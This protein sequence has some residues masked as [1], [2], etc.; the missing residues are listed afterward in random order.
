MGNSASSHRPHGHST[1]QKNR[2]PSLDL[3]DIIGTWNID[4]DDE[5]TLNPTP[6]DLAFAASRKAV[7]PPAVKSKD[8]AGAPAPTI[9][10]PSSHIQ[11]PPTIEEV[12]TTQPAEFTQVTVMSILPT[13]QKVEVPAV[14][15]EPITITWNGPGKAVF[16]AMAGDDDWKG[17]KELIQ[18]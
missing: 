10:V 5:K 6:L 12:P 7:S 4:G 3:P 2:P 1:N 17:R 8:F 11:V 13:P 15:L 14:R 18:E 16:V 9:D